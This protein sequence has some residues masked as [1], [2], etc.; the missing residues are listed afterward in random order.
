L[1][2][3]YGI[4]SF[5]SNSLGDSNLLAAKHSLTT[6]LEKH[7][8]CKSGIS[9]PPILP[10]RVLDLGLDES[11]LDGIFKLYESRKGERQHYSCLSYRWGEPGHRNLLT[12][13]RKVD[14]INGA[15]VLDLEQCIQDTI[16][17]IRKMGTRYLWI[18]ALCIIQDDDQDIATQIPQMKDIYTNATFV[19][20]A[21]SLSDPAQTF[22]R[23][24]HVPQAH[25]CDFPALID[26]NLETLSLLYMVEYSKDE[27]P[28][29]GEHKHY[30]E[31]DQQL[32]NRA[33]TLQECVLARRLLVCS[34]SEIFWHCQEVS[35]QPV[36]PSYFA[37]P[38]A[39]VPLD[40]QTL[41]ESIQESKED[42][43]PTAGSPENEV[44]PEWLFLWFG[45]IEDYTKR[46][47]SKPRDSLN[48]LGGIAQEFEFQ[49]GDKFV[50]GLSRKYLVWNL[51]WCSPFLDEKPHRWPQSPGKECDVSFPSWSWAG[52][53]LPVKMILCNE[54]IPEAEVATNSDD[55]YDLLDAGTLLLQGKM[56]RISDIKRKVDGVT[57]LDCRSGVDRDDFE[58][59]K[60]SMFYLYLGHSTE[61][62]RD[63]TLYVGM[64]AH[65]EVSSHYF[66]LV[67]DPVRNGQFERLGLVH[68]RQLG[69]DPDLLHAEW[70]ETSIWIR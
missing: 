37:Q 61:L 28:Q 45:L 11:A 24:R 42:V 56:T 17:V 6:C 15:Q 41:M 59:R 68:H 38:K 22:S 5:V 9:D 30:I 21:D 51:L 8:N 50:F 69:H 34:S 63:Y 64:A 27:N 49:T 40:R 13:N 39:L 35:N 55:T 12:K 54:F 66:Y 57:W 43:S 36:R 4:L 58:R 33:W 48:A 53:S 47:M 31:L 44:P 65:Q 60:S 14:F 19:L 29:P 23:P 46:Q 10:T 52:V 1:P 2:S 70:T 32:S 62:S 18:D 16:R 25:I 7:E 26:G 20:A 3:T 67:L